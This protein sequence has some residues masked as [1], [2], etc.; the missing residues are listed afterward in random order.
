MK[1]VTLTATLPRTSLKSLQSS[2]IDGKLSEMLEAKRAISFLFLKQ[3]TQNRITF[4]NNRHILWSVEKYLSENNKKK[5]KKN[6]DTTNHPGRAAVRYDGGS[7]GL[8]GCL[9]S[10]R[11]GASVKV[12]GIV[13]SST[14]SVTFR[15]KPSGLESRE[16]HLS[17]IQIKKNVPS[18]PED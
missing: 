2:L 3:N 17:F 16:F 4:V 11:K 13:T 14:L 7:I 15:T 6:K 5:N 18:Q 9:S 10:A 8:W 1:V 12:E